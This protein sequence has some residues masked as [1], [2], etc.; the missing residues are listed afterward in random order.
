MVFGTDLKGLIG[1]LLET[2]LP[3]CGLFEMMRKKRP[4]GCDFS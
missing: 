3:R 2:W 4:R 1:G